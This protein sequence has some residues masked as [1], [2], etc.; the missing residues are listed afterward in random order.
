MSTGE[1]ATRGSIWLTLVCY[2]ASVMLQLRGHQGTTAWARGLWT[3]GWLLFAAHLVLAFEHFYQWSHR[4]ALRETARQTAEIIGW[5]S[6][7]GLY[8]N[9]AFATVWLADGVWWWV[10]PASYSARRRA[11]TLAVQLFMGFIAING[12]IVFG[13]G[14]VRWFGC[15][16]LM[17][18]AWAAMTRPKGHCP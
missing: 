7:L 9:Y 13:Q 10:H 2:T 3:L 5:D 4:V 8:V 12:A 18:V 17:A 1:W 15:L 14:P 6:G 16:L 11:V